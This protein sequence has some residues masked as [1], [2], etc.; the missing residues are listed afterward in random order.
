MAAAL[1]PFVRKTMA[2]AAEKGIVLT[3]VPGGMGRM[4][5]RTSRRRRRS[6]RCPRCAIPAAA[7]RVADFVDQRFDRDHH[8]SGSQVPRAAADPRP[9]RRHARAR[10]GMRNSATRSSR[11]WA[12]RSSSTDLSRPG[13]SSGP[14]TRR[15]AAAAER[16]ELA[17]GAR[18]SRAGGAGEQ[19]PGRGSPDLGRYR[20]C[21]AVR[22]SRSYVG[23]V[24]RR[25]SLADRA[26]G[27]LDGGPCS[28]KL[29][30]T[31]IEADRRTHRGDDTERRDAADADPLP[32]VGQRLPADRRARPGRRT[33][34]AW[35][36]IARALADRT[37]PVGGD[38]LLLLEARAT[39]T[40]DV[41]DD[42]VQ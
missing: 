9:R 22:Q 5:A 37:G 2:Y 4:A 40:H 28:A 36:A 33:T 13:Y 3:L 32:R 30:A 14:A 16:D 26:S 23:V 6:A 20:G 12:V 38:G 8:L 19:F 18:L 31:L 21:L 15:I 29:F 34:T 27:Y 42:D 25:G 39:A 1:S 41:R 17:A 10:S 35:P 11:L 7:R 24:R